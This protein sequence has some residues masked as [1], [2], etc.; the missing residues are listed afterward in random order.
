MTRACAWVA[1]FD[2]SNRMSRGAEAMCLPG[3]V[4]FRVEVNVAENVALLA[5]KP[6]PKHLA[7]WS[8][9]AAVN[10]LLISR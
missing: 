1:R 10:D 3:D 5:S 4:S 7:T 2:V 6:S 8:L 9:D